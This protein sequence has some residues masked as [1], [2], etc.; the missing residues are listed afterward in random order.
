M[1]AAD[2]RPRRGWGGWRRLARHHSDG[3]QPCRFL[4]SLRHCWSVREKSPRDSRVVDALGSQ[5]QILHSR[6]ED[7]HA[8]YLQLHAAAGRSPTIGMTFLQGSWHRWERHR[9]PF[10][11]GGRCFFF[12]R[13]LLGGRPIEA[14]RWKPQ[15]EGFDAPSQHPTATKELIV[16]NENSRLS[17]P[18][19]GPLISCGLPMDCILI[20]K[21][22]NLPTH[23]GAIVH[24]ARYTRV[25]KRKS[26][27]VGTASARTGSMASLPL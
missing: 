4:H 24:A 21:A 9:S 2:R 22:Q 10:E 3:R 25:A 17:F 13:R 23:R 8:P 20:R 5:P 1:N 12:F 14:F 26:A 18:N 27:R 19:M 11:A 6:Q 15:D 16:M 7:R